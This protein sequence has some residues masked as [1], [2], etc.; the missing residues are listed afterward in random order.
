MQQVRGGTLQFATY[1]T[2]VRMVSGTVTGKIS[3]KGVFYFPI[4]EYLQQLGCFTLKHV[5]KIFTWKKK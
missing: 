5:K 4:M 3:S 1:P 2:N